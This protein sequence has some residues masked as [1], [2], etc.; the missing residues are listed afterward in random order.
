M[1]Y[2]NTISISLVAYLMGFASGFIIGKFLSRRGVKI[3]EGKIVFI[4]VTVIWAT[5]MLVDI[6]NP[7]YE[8]STLV[9]GIMGAIVGFFYKPG[10][11][12][13]E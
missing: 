6:L 4:V 3:D 10:K 9:H 7:E 8:T 1:D 12:K 11:T 5:S 13:D 2:I